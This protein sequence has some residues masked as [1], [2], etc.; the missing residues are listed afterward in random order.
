MYEMTVEPDSVIV[1]LTKI[2]ALLGLLRLF[3]FISAIHEWQFERRLSKEH[4]SIDQEMCTVTINERT[5]EQDNE[6]EKPLT[7]SE[8]YSFK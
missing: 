4:K 6:E 7:Y 2:G 5:F 1:A 8:F 3:F